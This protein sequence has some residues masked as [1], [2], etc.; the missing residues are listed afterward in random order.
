MVNT[1]FTLAALA[2]YQSPGCE[3]SDGFVEF[4]HADARI[5]ASRFLMAVEDE[6]LQSAQVWCGANSTCVGFQRNTY[7]NATYY[8]KQVVPLDDQRRLNGQSIVYLKKGSQEPAAL[9]RCLVSA[10][11]G[12]LNGLTTTVP[13]DDTFYTYAW[14][15]VI[16]GVELRRPFTELVAE[17]N[18]AENVDVIVGT[19][20]DEGT[21]FMSETPPLNCNATED[22]LIA[23]VQAFGSSPEVLTMY[24]ELEQPLPKCVQGRHFV[25]N[26][27]NYM[28]AMRLAGDIA[29]RCPARRLA[30][31]SRRP[32]YVYHFTM[33]PQMSLNFAETFTYGAFHGA[34]VP[35]VFG[36][37]GELKT[38]AERK[39]SSIMG[40]YWR[41]FMHHG[42]PNQGSCG[43]NW[44]QFTGPQFSVQKLGANVST[45]STLQETQTCRFISTHNDE[46]TRFLV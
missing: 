40:C 46:R 11:V 23:W 43:P 20:L 31:L 7:S 44:P 42:D 15:P 33:T 13:M 9:E 29:I 10:D 37:Q 5:D 27:I 26:P 17:G 28:K 36:Y 24:Q 25:Q 39:L 14:A 34:E 12:L 21:E 3:R 45:V 35:F 2:S 38:D 41:S 6:S 32:A 4:T 19:N 16:D 1:E 18:L 30:M 22:E 8:F